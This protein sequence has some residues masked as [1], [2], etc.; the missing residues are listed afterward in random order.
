PPRQAQ[1]PNVSLGILPTSSSAESLPIWPVGT[2]S[3][4]AGSLRWTPDLSR[5]TLK[6][7]RSSHLCDMCH[8]SMFPRTQI[9]ALA[10]LSA[11]AVSPAIAAPP[12]NPVGYAQSDHYYKK[13]T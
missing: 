3:R 10:L 12:A 4:A 9:Q 13:E 8:P 11:L 1:R 2:T 7:Q 5:R 6:K